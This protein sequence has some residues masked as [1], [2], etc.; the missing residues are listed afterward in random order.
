M[1]FIRDEV[2][3]IR[4][5]D[6]QSRIRPLDMDWVE[7]LRKM[8]EETGLQH[9]VSVIEENDGYRLTAGHHRLE[10]LK[11][12]DFPSIPVRVFETETDDP[13][14]EILLHE[15]VENIAR[16]PLTALDRAANLAEL[17]EVYERLHPETKHGGDRRSKTSKNQVAKMATWNFS[18]DM[19]EKTGISERT[20]QRAITIIKGLSLASRERLAGTELANNQAQLS[21][22]AALENEQQAKVL[23]L[24]LADDPEFGTVQDAVNHLQGKAPESAADKAYKSATGSLNRLTPSRRKDV[25]RNFANEIRDLAREEGWF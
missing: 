19:Q 5:I 6:V 4:A 21:Q 8:I 12:G 2:V 25:F 18:K 1:K 7:A 20:I 14:A 3:Q 11:Q 17:K 15:I 10:A 24:L 9:P 13:E 16:Q 23:D 22:L